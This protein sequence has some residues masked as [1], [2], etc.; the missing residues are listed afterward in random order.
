MTTEQ[1][2]AK[3]LRELRIRI[4][5]LERQMERIGAPMY[6]TRGNLIIERVRNLPKP[7]YKLRAN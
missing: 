5:V 1:E 2:L 4:V 3:E 6:S 7:N